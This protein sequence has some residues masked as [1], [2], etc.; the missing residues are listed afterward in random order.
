MVKSSP[1]LYLI[2]GPT[3]VGK[4]ALSLEI[5][6]YLNT[7][8]ISAD[9]RQFYKEISIGTAKPSKYEL[10]QIEHYFINNKS[11]KELYSA[12]EYEIDV[13]RLL[14]N[15]FKTNNNALIVGGSG[16]YIDAVCKGLDNIP[17]DL[18]IREKLNEE[19]DKFGIDNLKKQLRDLDPVH[20]HN[21]DNNNSQRLIRAIEVCKIINAPYSSLLNENKKNRPF[22]IVKILLH[23]NK[24]ELKTRIDKRVDKMIDDG[25]LSEVESLTKFRNYNALN[26]VGYKEIFEYLDGEISKDEAI[27]KIKINTRKYAK[28]QMTW[29]K[30][31][32]D[33]IWVDN[34]DSKKA[35]EIIK[36]IVSKN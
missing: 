28:R 4:T 26:T 24:E 1:T 25:L 5:A 20:F 18:K 14:D 36:S 15:Q 32:D 27:S 19:L 33:F 2:A 11:I 23:M 31:D 8:I 10:E 12:G 30:R 9:S 22:K 7:Y 29:F 3:A 35:I 21:M 16:M 6:K 34:V 13:L 17:R